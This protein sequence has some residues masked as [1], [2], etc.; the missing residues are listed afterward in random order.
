MDPISFVLGQDE[1]KFSSLTYVGP[2][3]AQGEIDVGEKGWSSCFATIFLAEPVS[4]WSDFGFEDYAYAFRALDDKW[5]LIYIDFT[6]VRRSDR[7]F[8]FVLDLADIKHREWLWF[9]HNAK[10]LTLVNGPTASVV[11][12]LTLDL[13]SP[14]EQEQ[15]R[16]VLVQT[17]SVHRQQQP[18]N[19]NN[20]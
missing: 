11:T 4:A 13:G 17:G 20:A 2:V 8:M 3:N 14:G 16:L 9:L 6:N 12:G 18:T 10:R 15:L 5:L 1:R 7:K 19:S